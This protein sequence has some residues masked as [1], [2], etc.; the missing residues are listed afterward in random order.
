MKVIPKVLII[1]DRHDFSSDFICVELD[2]RNVAYWRINRDELPDYKIDFEPTLPR[3]KAVFK[4]V[5]VDINV[6]T[7][8]SV[9]Y[10][11][12]TFL[13]DIFQNDADEEEQ[14]K[15]TQWAAFVRSLCV[16]EN[17][18]WLNNPVHTYQAEIKAYQLYKAKQIGFL[19]PATSITNHISVPEFDK[20][21]IKT[22]DT[23]VINL[24]EEEG[25]VYTEIYNKDELLEQHY[26]SPFFL[27]EGLV[28]KIDLRVT[29]AD[30]TVIAAKILTQE[31]KG[32]DIDWRRFKNEL[33][34]E[35]CEL[36][37]DVS[38]ICRR[39]VKELN[40]SFGGID[41]VIH[42]DQYYFIEI[43]PTGEWSWL[44]QNTGFRYDEAIT[45][46]LLAR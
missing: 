16:F 18:K 28:P 1:S 26:Q 41:L 9:Y 37:T 4:N 8:Q 13:R 5:E 14:L 36:P 29:V 22:I 6:D 38:E 10:R 40:L 45:N 30:E 11:A 34:Y 19:T 42:R 39:L 15:R 17:A 23:A 20:M 44:Q 21:A 32:I 25:F 27:Q 31:T 24:K 7:L 35:I 12:P 33:K 3:L 46:S 43:N 2:R